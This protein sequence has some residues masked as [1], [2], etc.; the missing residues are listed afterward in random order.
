MCPCV[1]AVSA[2]V[3]RFRSLVSGCSATPS[4]LRRPSWSLCSFGDGSSP[5]ADLWGIA[6]AVGTTCRVWWV[7]ARSAG[8]R[9]LLARLDRALR[10]DR[11]GSRAIKEVGRKRGAVEHS[12]SGRALRVALH[13]FVHSFLVLSLTILALTYIAPAVLDAGVIVPFPIAGVD[14]PLTW[15]LLVGLPGCVLFSVAGFFVVRRR[16]TVLRVKR[17][18]CL[19]CGYDVTGV[20]DVCPE[21]GRAVEGAGGRGGGVSA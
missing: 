1:S 21:C 16:L 9:H 14:V 6:L 20:D 5:D 18:Y 2:M 11:R 4:R 3:V 12:V 7:R 10:G 19:G 15:M 17:G 13:F 8:G